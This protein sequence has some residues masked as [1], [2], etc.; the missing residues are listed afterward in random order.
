MLW[1]LLLLAVHPAAAEKIEIEIPI[2][3]GG[4]GGE[5]FISVARQYEKIRPDVK[6]NLYGD[7]RMA[8]KVRVRVLEGTFF[9]ATNAL[10]NYWPLIENGDVL[11]LD[12]YLDGPNWEGD[13]TWRQSFVPGTLDSYTHKGKTYGV[14]FAL[15]TNV[16]WYNPDIFAAH[17]WTAP[18]TWEEFFA[19]CE[20]MRAAGIEPLAFQG[21]YPY[22]AEPIFASAY[23]SRGGLKAYQDFR[24]LEPGSLDSPLTVEALEVVKRFGANFQP[25]AM[26]MSHT[27]S[28]REFLLG[29]TAMLP[30][31]SWLKSEMLGKIPEGFRFR[32]FNLPMLAGGQGDATAMN[33]F[34][35]CYFIMSKSGHPREAVDFFRFMTSRA[36]A[37]RF[38][39]MRDI[40]TAIR[41]VPADTLSSDL[42][43]V[44]ALIANTRLN[45]GNDG[46]ETF[47]RYP[48]MSQPFEDMLGGVLTGRIEP[49]DAART[50][51]AQAAAV[52]GRAADPD[53]IRVRHIGKPVLLL[54]LVLGSLAYLAVRLRR[55]RRAGVAAGAGP[56]SG[57][58]RLRLADF[59]RFVL[60]ALLVYSLFVVIPSVRAFW[61][62]LHR[63]DGLS[64]VG[65]MSWVGLLNFERLLLESDGFWM[66]LG[67]NLFLMLVVPLF[68]VPLAMFLAVCLSRGLW[69]SALFRVVFFF[70]NLLGTVSIALLWM[71]LYNP[72]G[73]L[74]NSTLALVGFSGMEHFAWLSA[75]Y[76]YWALIPMS[77]WGA[78]GFNMVLYLAA[79]QGVPE[80]LYESAALEGAGPWRQFW[81]ITLPMIWDVLTI[82]IIFLIIAGMKAFDIIW[83]LTNQRPTSANHVISTRMVY[84]MFN[85]FHVGEATAMA[86]LLFVLVMLGSIF[87]MGVMRRDTIEA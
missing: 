7:P 42:A 52:R 86:V 11:P 15:F 33:A 13:S 78:C 84:V 74:V 28:Q 29:R 36:Q 49:V 65:S 56:G 57:G 87:S 72:Q 77:V 55:G 64:G 45:Y 3:T 66:A 24:N 41:G 67:N 82:S 18:K 14:P 34:S 71:H 68:V 81:S 85:D 39:K 51:G 69:G 19:L 53:A 2:F 31:G 30:C 6:V 4:E 35:P 62:S 40:P 1:G 46:A 16:I 37:A 80:E 63:W 23:Y 83:L 79:M 26:G 70:P 75:D 27:E 44:A 43:D 25:G 17:G 20:K 22:Y 12:E 47:L 38:G 5:F 60:P 58:M 8:D 54:T 32:A 76:L 50:L 10:T 9:E 59:A 73:G 21:R 48:E 61:W